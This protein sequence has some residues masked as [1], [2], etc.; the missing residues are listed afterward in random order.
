MNIHFCVNW[1]TCSSF[2]KIQ[3]GPPSLNWTSVS[4]PRFQVLLFTFTNHKIKKVELD[5]HLWLKTYW[6]P[7]LHILL[8]FSGS[9]IQ[10]T[11]K[12]LFG[13]I[14]MLIKLVP[15]NSAGTVTAY[16]ASSNRTNSLSTD[17]TDYRLQNLKEVGNFQLT[18]LVN[19]IQRFYLLRTSWHNSNW[20]RK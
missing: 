7:W 1:V 4:Q 12:F 8:F 17:N 10:S 19:Q 5:F 2:T 11:E 3:R 20:P 18:E 13:S 6:P 15:G 9:G 14:E 16:Y